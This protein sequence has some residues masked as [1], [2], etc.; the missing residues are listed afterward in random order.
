MPA[1]TYVEGRRGTTREAWIDSLRPGD[2]GLV[3]EL[4]ALAKVEGRKDRRYAD[5]LH[6]KDAIHERGALIY[7]ASTGHRSDDRK[8]W[9]QMRDRAYA[10]LDGAVKSG[11]KGKPQLGFTDRELEIM[12]AVMESRNYRNWPE[13]Q[14]A[15]EARGI[16]P[17]GRTW[18]L[19]KLPE[20]AKRVDRLVEIT[21][22]PPKYKRAPSRAKLRP[23][24][25]VYFIQCGEAVKIGRSVKPFERVAS[26]S[27]S[28][29][30]ALELLA[31]T[32]G[33][34]AEEKALHKKFAAY[35]IKGE[36]FRYSAEIAK[37][38]AG[39]SRKRKLK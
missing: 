32:P 26:L 33:S 25:Q 3:P 9:P 22:A 2:A 17:P 23:P 31:T 19:E 38:I 29:H 15:M 5:L 11:K 35:H 28:N 1:E 12:Q 39:I 30:Q 34:S 4:F 10:L 36:W 7:E 18:C 13:R 14:D 21:P 24:S 37:F 8:Q 16:K 20:M 27:T 6:A